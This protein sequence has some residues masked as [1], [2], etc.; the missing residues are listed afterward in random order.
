MS[1]EIKQRERESVIILDL[2]G[3]L[4]V[5]E[6]ASSMRERVRALLEAGVRNL[7]LNLQECDYIDSTGLGTLVIC[8]TSVQKAGGKLKLM[9]L[10]RRNIELLVLTK[11]ETIFEIFNEEQDAVNSFF[12]NREIR[13]FDILEFVKQQ[14]Q[15]E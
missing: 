5:G 9:K 2:N 15:E 12:P 6:E 3:R 10:T 1:I 13:R 11:L 14:Q 4:T 8:Y 7:I